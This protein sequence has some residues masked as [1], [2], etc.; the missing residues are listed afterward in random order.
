MKLWL[1]LALA[2]FGTAALVSSGNAA[3]AASRP[4]SPATDGLQ[5]YVAACYP[6]DPA[7][8]TQGL[9]YHSGYLYESTGLVG[10]SSVRRVRIA[11]G[12]ILQSVAVP[13]PYFGEGMT[14]WKSELISITWRSGLAFRWDR[15]SLKQRATRRYEGEGWGLTQDGRHLILSDGT[16]NLRF[17]DPESFA[18]ERVVPVTINA[19]ALP[20][21]NELEWVEGAILANVWQAKQIVRIDPQTGKVTGILDFTSLAAIAPPGNSDAVLNGIAYDSKGK[22]LFVTGKTWPLMFDCGPGSDRTMCQDV[23]NCPTLRSSSG[24]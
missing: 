11:D 13:A 6:H 21:L 16:A 8:F 22:R 4:A 17:L 14:D 2:W 20:A 23:R 5:Y 18:V 19:I 10:Q 1:G 7:A 15:K 3:P 12:K 9:I 24:R